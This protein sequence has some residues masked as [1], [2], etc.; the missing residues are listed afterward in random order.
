MNRAIERIFSRYGLDAEYT[1]PGGGEAA[2]LRAFVQPVISARHSEDGDNITPIGSASDAR[3]Y[4]IG[5]AVPAPGRGGTLTAGGEQYEFLR[6]GRIF[7]G[8]EP[9]HCEGV[10]KLKEGV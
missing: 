6:A 9:S 10:L 5:P 7:A 1:P 2:A 4:Y 8:F 3:W